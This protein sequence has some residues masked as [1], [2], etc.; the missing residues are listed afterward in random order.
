MKPIEFPQQEI[1]LRKPDTMTHAECG[2]LPIY[3]TAGGCCISCWQASL[4][5]RLKFLFTGKL[6]VWVVSG[7]TQPPIYLGIEE[8]EWPEQAPIAMP[9]AEEDDHS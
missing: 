8:P 9:P 6:W 3:R 7:R 4:W 2:S 5:D 1:T